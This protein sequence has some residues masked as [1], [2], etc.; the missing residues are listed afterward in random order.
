[1]EDKFQG[2]KGQTGV[3]ILEGFCMAGVLRGYLR[4]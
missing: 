1:M 4:I 2:I 3:Q